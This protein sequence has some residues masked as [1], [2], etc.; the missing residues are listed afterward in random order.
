MAPDI[1]DHLVQTAA[2]GPDRPALRQG[3]AH[4]TYADVLEA[5]DAMARRF[6]AA[7]LAAGSVVAV[8]CENRPEVL[9]AY[10]AAARLSAIFVPI[11]PV[12]S[13]PEVAHVV[14]DSGAAMLVHDVELTAV[15][16]AAMA[17]PARCWTF[18]RLAESAVARSP[19]TP[20]RAAA[21]GDFL[22][23]YTSGSTGTPKAVVFDQAAEFNGNASLIDMWGIGPADV[24]L[25]ALPLGFLYGL[26]TAAA[27]GLQAGGEVVLLRRFHPRDVLNALI[28]AG[29]S[30]FHGVPTMFAMMLSYAESEGI[31]VDLRAVRLLIAAGAPL[32]QDLRIRF[33][34]RFGKH[35]DDY[36]ALT[37]ARPLF[38]RRYDDPQVPPP[39]AIGRAAPGVEVRIVGDGDRL[40]GVR[41]HGE[42]VVRAPGMFVRYA[43]APELTAKALGPLGF[44]TGDLGYSDEQ[45][46]YY[47]T[48]RIKDIIIRGGANIAPAEVEH[49]LTGH[50]DVQLAAVVGTPDR[51]F[52]EVVAAFV[53]L[54]PGASV[55]ESGLIEHCH[56]RL[57]TFK[58]P[59][60]IRILNAMP[61]GATGKI[62]KSALRAEL[63]R[64]AP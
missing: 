21:P 22:V 17:D 45:G 20:S 32:A 30:V 46:Y 62:D 2:A 38:G 26:S 44:R 8:L 54:R 14:R 4:Y 47:L 34:Q 51:T 1:F 16:Q 40:L 55:T 15:A 39:G 57:A 28:E 36:Y 50:P 53:T 25:V 35:I 60:S 10:Y 58:V 49:V 7:G 3:E 64:T 12:L 63:T 19:V 18:E 6:R 27:T 43:K 61:L 31:E 52:G 13:P 29:V 48:G 24:T 33:E 42:V 41:E 11:N 56:G 37:E 5:V 9:F 23:I 59:A